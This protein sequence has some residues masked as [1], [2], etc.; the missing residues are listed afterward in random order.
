MSSYTDAELESLL[1]DLE[2]DWAER[3]ESFKGNAPSEAREAVCAFANDLPDH[4]RPGV[5]FIGAKDNGEPSGLA[6]TDELLRN[7]AAIKTDGNILPPP[8]LTVEK[9]VLAGTP[10]AVITVQPADAP[11]V[12]FKGRIWIRIGPRRGT[13]TAQDERILNERRRSHDRPFDVQPVHGASLGDL[14]LARFE[15]EYLPSAVAPDI[16]EANDRTRE[17]R[18][19]A[20]KMVASADDP[21][22][23]VLGVLVVGKTT[24][25]FLEGA[26]VQFLRIEGADL[27]GAVVDELAVDGTVADVIRRLEEKIDAHNRTRVDFTTAAVEQRTEQYPTVALQQICRNAILHRTYEST[28]SPVRVTWFDDRIE[29]VSPGGPFGVVTA[30]NFGTPGIADYRNPNLAEAMKVLGYAQRFGSGIV[31][32]QRAMS[33]NGNPPVEFQV[34]PGY[35]MAVLRS[36]R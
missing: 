15:S 32:A 12:R 11:P 23:T 13:A 30:E 34:D 17:Q 31:L 14:D 2:S 27:S 33:A 20:A 1:R 4:R 18:L 16:L 29:V 35:V 36:A 19:A 28:N 5:V 10:M 8:S 26:Y 7:L 24:R 21:V 25:T 6:I 9:R 22:P 3:K